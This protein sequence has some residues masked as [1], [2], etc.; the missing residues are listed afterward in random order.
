MIAP[1][2]VAKI[3]DFGL[4]HLPMSDLTRT[5]TVIGT[6]RYMSP[7]QAQG[8]ILDY[9]TDI[10]SLGVVL[11]AVCVY[12]GAWSR[13]PAGDNPW[14]AYTLE[15]ATSSPPPEWNFDSLPPIRSERPVWDAQREATA[16]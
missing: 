16:T 1:G 13:R 14:D 6:P 4:A 5:G 11:F 10:F 8:Q 3:G 9:R 7:E 12:L 2:N 15:W